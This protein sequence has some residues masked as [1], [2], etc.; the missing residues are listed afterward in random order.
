MRISFLLD[1]A[2]VWADNRYIRAN[3][4]LRS[5]LDAAEEAQRRLRQ[6]L[7]TAYT[8]NRNLREARHRLEQDL[9]AQSGIVELAR[10]WRSY[11]HAPDPDPEVWARLESALGRAIDAL[12][13]APIRGFDEHCADAAGVAG[14]EASR[15]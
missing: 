5:K 3:R 1:L 11:Y 9:V 2:G 8:S 12:P 6:Q 10:Q 14:P 15:P 4:V 7:D 13:T